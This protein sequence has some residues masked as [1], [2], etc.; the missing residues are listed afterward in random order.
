M[1]SI[2]L[3]N[4]AL[5]SSL[6]LLEQRLDL[7]TT[8]KLPTEQFYSAYG[9]AWNGA[10]SQF[11]M[12]INISLAGCVLPRV[13]SPVHWSARLSPSLSC[14]VTLRTLPSGTERERGSEGLLPFRLNQLSDSTR[15]PPSLPPSFPPSAASGR[16]G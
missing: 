2:Q 13:I 10:P 1:P 8:K 6:H 7:H 11:M 14:A 16:S 4:N 3:F 5:T 12:G 15:L 9:G